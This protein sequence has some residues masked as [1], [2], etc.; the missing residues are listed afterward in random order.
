MECFQHLRDFTFEGRMNVTKAV[1][2]SCGKQL[3]IKEF[4]KGL[5]FK[6]GTICTFLKAKT[7]LV[8]LLF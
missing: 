5:H 8:V 6:I 3:V 2:I 1:N 7:Y 4:L